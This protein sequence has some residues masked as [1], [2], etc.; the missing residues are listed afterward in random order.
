MLEK[1]GLMHIKSKIEIVKEVTPIKA[2]MLENTYTSVKNFNTS[3]KGKQSVVSSFTNRKY[4]KEQTT[5]GYKFIKPKAN[6]DKTSERPS[7]VGAKFLSSATNKSYSN[8]SISRVVNLK[9]K[10]N[11]QKENKIGLL[12]TEYSAFLSNPKIINANKIS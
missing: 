8:S 7:S 1:N 9:E 11:K 12:G 5:K 6:E 3:M 4:S 10:R 2:R